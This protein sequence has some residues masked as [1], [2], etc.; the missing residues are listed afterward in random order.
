MRYLSPWLVVLAAGACGG[1]K[2]LCGE[3]RVGGGTVTV[4][5]TT[6]G[7]EF[8]FPFA[9]AAEV[10]GYPT[11]GGWTTLGPTPD[12]PASVSGDW[13]APLEVAECGFD[14]G[15][16]S[17][18]LTW[19]PGPDGALRVR[20]LDFTL[21]NKNQI[22][23][24][25]FLDGPDTTID[26]DADLITGTVVSEGELSDSG[27]IEECDVVGLGPGPATLRVEWA[28]DPTTVYQ[29]WYM[30]RGECSSGTYSTYSYGNT[31]TTNTTPTRT[32]SR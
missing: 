8:S 13:D 22:R 24:F 2:V 20:W 15:T 25:S 3:Q 1:P 4:T 28:F 31:N 26:L 16:A 10:E 32:T 5:L 30:T 21:W 23:F 6:E 18:D 11:A 27:S 17:L 12:D 29:E 19:S 14:E 9:G 7:G